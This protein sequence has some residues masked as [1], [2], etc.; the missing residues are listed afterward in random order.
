MKSVDCFQGRL[1]WRFMKASRKH[2]WVVALNIY[3]AFPRWRF[4]HSFIFLLKIIRYL[5]PQPHR[6]HDQS[7]TVAGRHKLMFTMVSTP[8]SGFFALTESLFLVQ[9]EGIYSPIFFNDQTPHA[10][11]VVQ[12]IGKLPKEVPHT[13]RQDK[14][15]LNDI[16]L[17]A[18]QLIPASWAMCQIPGLDTCKEII[19]MIPACF[20]P[21]FFFF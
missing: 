11:Y 16:F 18:T 20:W 14:F 8:L 4:I 2:G 9:D 10:R 13:P 1:T 5:T 12:T 21:F 19:H 7:N 15:P 17:V 3:W 6:E